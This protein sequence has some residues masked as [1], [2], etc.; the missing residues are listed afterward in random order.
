[1]ERQVLEVI[2]LL[3]GLTDQLAYVIAALAILIGINLGIFFVF[4]RIGSCVSKDIKEI[5]KL[6][7]TLIEVKES[8]E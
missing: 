8:N 1:M 6:L 2:K 5:K 4:S 3:G 7:E